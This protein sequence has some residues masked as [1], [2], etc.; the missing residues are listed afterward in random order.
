MVVVFFINSVD[1]E[2]GRWYYIKTVA[3]ELITF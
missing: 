2:I 3:D 1:E